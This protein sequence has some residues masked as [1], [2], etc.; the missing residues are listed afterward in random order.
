ML[1]HE[2]GTKVNKN[3]P[4][5][6]A[7]LEEFYK[8]IVQYDPEN[9]YNMDK[10]SL[11]FQLLLIYTLLMPNKDISTTRRKKKAKDC[12]FLIVCTNALE[13]TKFHVH[14]LGN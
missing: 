9:V 12:V 10:T 2:K 5:L 14:W 4:K 1:L 7:A 3:D 11:F 13:C 8:I 6:L